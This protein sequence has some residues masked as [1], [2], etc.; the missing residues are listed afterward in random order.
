[1]VEQQFSRYIALLDTPF[2]GAQIAQL[3][4]AAAAQGY[5]LK[6]LEPHQRYPEDILRDCPILCG[7]FPKKLLKNAAALRWLQLPSAGADKFVDESIYPH[8]NVLL[9]NSSGA[10]G[11]A[12]AEQ[13]IMGALMLLRRMPEY[14]AQQRGKIWRRVGP[15]GFLRGSRVTVLGTG[16]LGGTFGTYCQAMGAVVRGV[17]RSGES[18]YDCFSA[19]YPVEQLKEAVRDADILAACLPLTQETQGLL[20]REIFQAMQPGGI[21]LN[22]GR[23][24]TVCQADLIEALQTGRLGGAMLDVAET[25]PMPPECPLWD[26]ENVI[27]TPHV[28]GSDRDNGGAIFAIFMDNLDRFFRDQPLKNIVDKQKGY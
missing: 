4:Q 25:E 20:D 5:G 8:E 15:M 11:A 18:A 6:L 26:M 2:D 19:L 23:G 14:Q 28:S 10:F 7:Y 24:K 21:F 16:N 13:L 22:V 3:R 27:L 1:M 9:T 17:S 12:I